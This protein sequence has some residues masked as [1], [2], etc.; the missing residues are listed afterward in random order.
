MG[1]EAA[2]STK[3]DARDKRD[4]VLLAIRHGHL[5]RGCKFPSISKR[6]DLT[7]PWFVAILVL[8]TPAENDTKLAE[9]LEKRD[10]EYSMVLF[11]DREIQRSRDAIKH[12]ENNTEISAEVRKIRIDANQSNIDTKM[13]ERNKHALA[14]AHLNLEAAPYQERYEREQWSRF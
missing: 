7:P 13:V 9:I 3:V 8:M 5:L 11:Y 4:Y 2:K 1:I 12:N 10:K 6:T 14:V